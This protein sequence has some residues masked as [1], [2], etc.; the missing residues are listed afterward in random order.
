MAAVMTGNKHMPYIADDER[1]SAVRR[2]CYEHTCETHHWCSVPLSGALSSSCALVV[3]VTVSR[4]SECCF[5]IQF[6]ILR[7]KR[8]FTESHVRIKC[9]FM[10]GFALQLGPNGYAFIINHNGFVVFHPGLRLIQV[11]HW[12]FHRTCL[13]LYHLFLRS[14]HQSYFSCGH[15]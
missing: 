7:L 13:S 8:I 5:G 11:P 15:L 6:D 9:C 10:G 14:D 4:I 1:Q 2:R 3:I 12:I